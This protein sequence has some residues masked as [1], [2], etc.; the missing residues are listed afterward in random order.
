MQNFQKGCFSRSHI[1]FVYIRFLI[2]ISSP[3]T[4]WSK[5]PSNNVTTVSGKAGNQFG[6]HSQANWRTRLQTHMSQVGAKIADCRNE[7]KQKEKVAATLG[8]VLEWRWGFFEESHNRRW[9]LCDTLWSWT[10][11]NVRRIPS[12]FLPSSQ[13]DQKWNSNR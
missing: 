2:T 3:S 9:G 13:K 5:K 7:E 6:N 10:Y 1:W 8:P 12:S 4:L 11:G